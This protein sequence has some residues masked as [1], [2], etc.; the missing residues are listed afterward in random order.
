MVLIV[1]DDADFINLTRLVLIK[2][3]FEVCLANSVSEAKII[4]AQKAVD[5][6]LC[7]ISMPGE[8]GQV[9]AQYIVEKKLTI[10]F[11]FMTGHT[12]ETLKAKQIEGFPV[13][14]KPFNSKQL[15]D[16]I[17]NNFRK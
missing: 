12:E 11:A 2:S 13:L 17:K 10:N 9:L 8:P 6:I 5:L 16:F 4:L 7:D 15:L 1:D 14:H 3:G